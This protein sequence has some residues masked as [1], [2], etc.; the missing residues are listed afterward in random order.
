VPLSYDLLAKHGFFEGDGKLCLFVDD[1]NAIECHGWTRAT[2]GNCLIVWQTTDASPGPHRI[3]AEFSLFPGQ[4]TIRATGPVTLITLTN[5]CHINPYIGSTY[6]KGVILYADLSDSNA[7]YNIELLTPNGNHIKTI[8]GNTSNGIL[9]ERWNLTDD[10]GNICT[11]SSV[12]AI[13]HVILPN[14][15]SET[16]TQVYNNEHP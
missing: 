9:N 1:H 3:N 6:F 11:N 2:N 12:N 10:H 8:T 4:R 5:I 16:K 7:S 15:L 13:Y 14:S